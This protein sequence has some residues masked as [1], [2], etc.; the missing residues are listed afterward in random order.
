M[1]ALLYLFSL[2][3]LVIGSGAFLI[4]GVLQQVSD[5]LG[6]SVAAAGQAMTAYAM[7]TALLAPL[8]LV[9]TGHWSRRSAAV[10][11]LVLFAAGNA[12]CALAPGLTTLLA[13]RALMG[14]GAVFTPLS[15]GVAVVLVEPAT[16]RPGAGAG[17]PRHRPQLRG[18]HP[19]R[20]LARR[21]I[22]AGAGRSPGS[23]WRRC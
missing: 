2:T 3:N 5:S 6:V 10:L 8:L 9:A 20:R 15:A 19:A 23:A 18:R 11:G 16:A 13:G 22:S 17:V 21:C 1:P 12:V 7:A 4:G 14:L